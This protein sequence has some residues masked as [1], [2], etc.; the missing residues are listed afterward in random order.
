MELIIQA[1]NIHTGGGAVLLKDLIKSLSYNIETILILDERF[2]CDLEESEKIKI[3]KIKPTIFGR[4]KA[5]F[6][7]KRIAASA[8]EFFALGAF[9]RYIE[10]VV[11]FFFLFR[12]DLL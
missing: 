4:L 10:A 6:I 2:K 1:C 3:V 5:D 9:L 11:A 7:L 8:V 12:T